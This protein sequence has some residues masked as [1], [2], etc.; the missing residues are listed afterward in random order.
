VFYS[1]TER[2]FGSGQ[3]DYFHVQFTMVFSTSLFGWRQILSVQLVLM[4]TA[5]LAGGCATADTS[6]NTTENGTPSNG[7]APPGS[8]SGAGGAGGVGDSSSSG[9]GGSGG[10]SGS[11]SGSGSGSSSG[12]GGVTGALDVCVLN[13][14]LPQD[15]CQNPELLAYGDVGAG[16]QEMR[17]FRIDNGFNTDALFKSV[18]I[19]SADFSI[20]TVRYEVDPGDPNKLIRIAQPL[21]AQRP[22]DTALY[23]EVTFTAK[24]N[25]G[26]LP[27]TLV[28]IDAGPLGSTTVDIV[29]PIDGQTVGCPT[30]KA[31]CD[32][33]PTNGCETDTDTSSQ[34]CG[35]CG[36]ACNLPNTTST[37]Q[38]GK[39]AVDQCTTFFADCNMNPVDGC[40]A[41]LLND[42]STCGACNIDC[43]KANTSVIC[44]GGNCGLV[45]CAVGYADCNLSILDGCE[46]DIL[47][48]KAHCGGCN[49]NCDL[50]NASE[51]C[52]A[53]A[54]GLIACNPGFENCD[55]NPQTGCEIDLSNDV[56]NCGS[57]SKKCVFNNGAASCV[58]GDCE[59]GACTPGFENCNAFDPD[60][61]EA[62]LN[63]SVQHCGNCGTDCTAAFPHSSV[64]CA[65]GTC[66]FQ[67][68]LPGFTDIDGDLTNGCEYAC[69]FT[70]STDD[71][72]DAFAD[73]NCDGIDG[74]VDKAIFVATSGND[75]NLGT[76]QA[77]MATINGAI[78]KALSTAKKQIYISDGLYNARVTL[79]NGVSLY[80]G[81][82]AANKWKRQAAF[83]AVIRS[84]TVSGGRVSALEG[85]N[86]TSPTT[87]DRL[88]IQTLG[89][90][91]AGI[92]NYAMHCNGCVAVTLKNSTLEAGGAGP[93]TSGTN[94]SA[95]A[96]GTNG[97]AGGVGSCDTNNN[98]GAGGPGGS[99]TCGRSGGNGGKGGN[100]GAN[101]G[102]NGSAGVGPTNGGNG[103]SG[104]TTGSK[105]NN[106]VNGSSGANGQNGTGGNN[107][108][109]VG[110][111]WVGTAGTNGQNGTAGN[112]AGGGG[113]G[114]GQGC[115]F[116]DVCD[117]GPGNGGGG[118][119][120]G[121]C[122]G[123][124]ATG[125][126]AGGSSFGLF[127][128]NS[129]GFSLSGN[130]IA[131]GNG[132]NGGSAGTGGNG[133]NGGG[134]GLGSQVCTSEVGGGGN[135]GVGGNGGRGGHGGGGAG[136]LSFGV[137]RS[138]SAVSTAGNILTNSSGGSGGSSL[139]S[140]GV[141]GASGGVF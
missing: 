21:P 88:T 66:S 103:G 115:T 24:G 84:A 130:N 128:L 45:G 29:V 10:G 11:S 72:D 79:A 15:P 82:S 25:A 105:G 102:A 62:N 63:T 35:G 92:S 81:Y 57:C 68:C 9:A 30:G 67:G 125:G 117:D 108:S 32:T 114:G 34:N 51:S 101:K 31:A 77:P 55:N 12:S 91:T 89:T 37:C 86:I 136:G 36:K 64:S 94:G 83:I 135:G 22:P 104:G 1:T 119:G 65:T 47:N 38:D 48:T 39:C 107:G 138:G 16:T 110:G 6:T 58:A 132:G 52:T 95:G 13:K 19:N 87:I 76:Q 122:G 56:N 80:G 14:G 23:F 8:A 106:G 46:T 27:A 118:G 40:E 131:S 4:T 126:A 137:Y 7:G 78:G 73:Q 41:N 109:I 123:A 113:G 53:G 59:L 69:T 121:G 26:P 127:L 112:G 97:Q 85:T 129:T 93:G 49:K 120:A 28:H 42:V 74:D 111:F 3:G 75:S 54:C 70:S 141:A 139:G 116:P 124:L 90:S 99:S 20:V 133:G 96:N 50:A 5:V 134:S 98:G 44:N 33:D 18:S 100:F 43:K 60:G 17:L 2:A 61:C 71:P 140:S